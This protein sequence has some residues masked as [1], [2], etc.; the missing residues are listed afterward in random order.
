MK[1]IFRV[2]SML[3]LLGASPLEAHPLYLFGDI[4]KA[5]VLVMLTRNGGDLSGWYLYLHYAKE[6]RLAGR[7][8]AKGDFSLDEFGGKG[9]SKSGSFSGH[10]A[11]TQWTGTWRK[12]GGAP[13]ALALHENHDTLAT[14]SG[15][16][17]CQTKR[18]DREFGYTY[19]HSLA[20]GMA[21][22]RI[23]KL[24]MFLGETS[25]EGDD[26]SCSLGLGDL[27]QVPSDVGI[28][29]KGKSTDSLEA[30]NTQRCTIRIVGDGDAL[31]VQVGGEGGNDDCKGSGDA[32]FCS[33]RSFWTDML[34]DRKT[35]VC[36]SVE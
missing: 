4:A 6:I 18:V 16:L 12:P 33:P 28:L 25:K 36:K 13:L 7:I 27:K 10:V 22:G 2:A 26:Q 23:A 31:Y 21:H 8:D 20:L 1:N 24:D 11:G 30:T 35:Q 14:L 5:P 3:S 9:D 32:M 17:R 34:A 29:L 19:T 15:G